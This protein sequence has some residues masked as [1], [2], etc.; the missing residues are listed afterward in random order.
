MNPPDRASQEQLPEQENIFNDVFDTGHYKKSMKNARIWLYVIAGLQFLMGIYEYTITTDKTIATIA[1][2]I[3]GGIALTFC[4]LALWSMKNP[5]AAFTT[6]LIFYIVIVVTLMILDPS[7]IY[8]GIIVKIFVL[9]ALFKA[10]RDSRKFVEA[11][12][13]LGEK[14]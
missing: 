8:R 2:A 12:S 3:D 4:L 5:V 1:F 14:I 11:Q 13:S 9:I 10:N 7:N 6:A